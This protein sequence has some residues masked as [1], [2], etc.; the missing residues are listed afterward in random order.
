MRAGTVT[1]PQRIVVSPSRVL[2]WSWDLLPT[3]G[4]PGKGPEPG[5]DPPQAAHFRQD[6]RISDGR[7][8]THEFA[9]GTEHGLSLGG[10]ALQQLSPGESD[11]CSMPPAGLLLRKQC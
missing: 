1:Q 5:G 4:P 8:T 9:A 11:S 2:R 7:R 6:E 3:G 10:I